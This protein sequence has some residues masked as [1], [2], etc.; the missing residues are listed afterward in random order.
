MKTFYVKRHGKLFGPLSATQV[1]SCLSKDIFTQAD[2]ISP[3]RVNW[4]KMTSFVADEESARNHRTFAAQPVNWPS[5]VN[6]PARTAP[7]QYTR[8]G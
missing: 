7:R 3:D 8:R 4:Q 2:Q 6:W 1:A 5:P